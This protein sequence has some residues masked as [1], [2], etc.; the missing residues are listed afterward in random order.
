MSARLALQIVKALNAAKKT[1][2]VEK[3]TSIL[4]NIFKSKSAQTAAKLGIVGTGVATTG[5]LIGTGVNQAVVQP[6]RDLGLVE[7]A[8]T[9]KPD[10]KQTALG[11]TLETLKNIPKLTNTGKFI[12]IAVVAIIGIMVVASLLRKK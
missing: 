11:S 7:Q 1:Q 5:A 2:K 3:S 4:A 8:D 9:T 12:L 10:R 6:L